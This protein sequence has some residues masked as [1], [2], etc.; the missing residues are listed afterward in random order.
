MSVR[1]AVRIE[2]KEARASRWDYLQV[3]ANEAGLSV[4]LQCDP[5]SEHAIHQSPWRTFKR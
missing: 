4:R 2:S 5:H 1:G 3:V